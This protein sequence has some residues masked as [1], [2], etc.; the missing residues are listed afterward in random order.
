MCTSHH[1]RR[2]SLP[3]TTTARSPPGRFSAVPPSRVR[4]RPQVHHYAARQLL[5]D[6]GCGPDS[7]NGEGGRRRS[8]D[9]N[10]IARKFTATIPCVR[11]RTAPPCAAERRTV[12]PEAAEKNGLRTLRKKSGNLSRDT[13]TRVFPIPGRNNPMRKLHFPSNIAEVPRTAPQVAAT[14]LTSSTLRRR[15]AGRGAA[16]ARPFGPRNKT[17]ARNS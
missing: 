16:G 5:G 17:L 7:E 13:W 3:N 15:T 11:G 9:P 10:R 4:S 8:T 6:L 12:T 14:S 1:P 2:E